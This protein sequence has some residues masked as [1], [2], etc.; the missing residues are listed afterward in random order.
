[1]LYMPLPPKNTPIASLTPGR[2]SI[3]ELLYISRDTRIKTRVS[4][5]HI[6]PL[7]MRLRGLAKLQAL[8]ELVVPVCQIGLSRQQAR[9][10][11]YTYRG[12]ERCTQSPQER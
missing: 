1:M 3:A 5:M 9:Y 2:C 11:S 7:E 12:H 8:F 10:R 4:L 6:V